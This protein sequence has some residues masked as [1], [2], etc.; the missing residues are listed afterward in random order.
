MKIV[1]RAITGLLLLAAAV[2]MAATPHGA[3]DAMPNFYQPPADMMTHTGEVVDIIDPDSTNPCYIVAVSDTNHPV[4]VEIDCWAAAPSY[5]QSSRAQYTNGQRVLVTEQGGVP[6]ILSLEPASPGATQPQT[7]LRYQGVDG[8]AVVTIADGGVFGVKGT[9]SFQLTPEAMVLEHSENSGRDRYYFQTNADGIAAF[10]SVSGMVNRGTSNGSTQAPVGSLLLVSRRAP[11][12]EGNYEASPDHR[13][14]LT[15]FGTGGLTV[16]DQGM[17]GRISTEQAGATPGVIPRHTHEID[18]S[19]FRVSDKIV[20]S[21]NARLGGDP[22]P[23]LMPP[24]APTA[25]HSEVST[26]NRFFVFRNRRPVT[27]MTLNFNAATPMVAGDYRN[28][29][30]QPYRYY[31]RADA[32]RTALLLNATDSDETRFLLIDDN[33]NFVGSQH[34]QRQ[35][36]A[37][38]Q[39]LQ[40]GSD[41]FRLIPSV[42]VRPAG[43]L[44]EGRGRPRLETNVPTDEDV[45]LPA[46]CWTYGR[47]V[48]YQSDYT[49]QL[50]G[51][52]DDWQI[53]FTAVPDGSVLIAGTPGQYGVNGPA[54]LSMMNARVLDSA[55]NAATLPDAVNTMLVTGWSVNTYVSGQRVTSLPSES[56]F[57]IWMVLKPGYRIAR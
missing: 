49:A 23:D 15:P 8:A 36:A 17:L 52:D 42:R 45:A 10:G 13:I 54:L 1:K 57:T 38:P 11:G 32:A 25:P 44:Y 4:P 55:G 43:G 56:E 5:H 12:V 28:Q 34:S 53:G 29:W 48:D 30:F 50:P 51:G 6:T 14:L 2:T 20:V 33:F 7:E 24:P 37:E 18:L 31:E 3:A 46:F 41:L 40:F 22:A 19:M 16:N 27:G 35:T 21:E 9:S 39:T 26:T 47:R